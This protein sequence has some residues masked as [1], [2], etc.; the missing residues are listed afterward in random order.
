[1]WQHAQTNQFSTLS[2]Y[3]NQNYNAA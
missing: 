1:M 3:I 2:N